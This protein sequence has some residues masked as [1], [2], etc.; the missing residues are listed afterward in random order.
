MKVVYPELVSGLARNSITK[1]KVAEA[2]GISPR[3]LYSKLVGNTE[4]TLSEANIIQNRFF[5]DV[6]MD[7]LFRQADDRGA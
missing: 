3:T 2:L 1:T 6:E 7:D 5:P 4:F